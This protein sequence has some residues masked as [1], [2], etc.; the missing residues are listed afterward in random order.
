MLFQTEDITS[1][2][3]TES[4]YRCHT[5]PFSE[6]MIDIALW[7][8]TNRYIRSVTPIKLPDIGSDHYPIIFKIDANLSKPKF[9]RKITQYHRVDWT[10]ANN[11]I[12]NINLDDLSRNG[13][14]NIIEKVEDEIRNIHNE[15]PTKT[16]TT[17]NQGLSKEI[18]QKIKEKRR[19]IKISKRTRKPE[20]KRAVNRISKEIK[21]D[22][23]DSEQRKTKKQIDS[24]QSG[25]SRRAWKDFNN[26]FRKKPIEQISEIKDPTTNQV[27]TSDGD[28]AEIFR[29][30]QEEIFKGNPVHD[31]EHEDRV[32]RWFDS[33]I[34][35][36]KPIQIFIEKAEIRKKIK[37]LKNNKAPGDDGVTNLLIKYLE[38]SL[39]DILFQIY[40]SCY[41]YGMFPDR[42]KLAKIKMLHK[43]ESKLDPSNYRPISLLNQFGKIFESLIADI[44]R[45]WAEDNNKL[46]PIQAGFR[47]KRSTNDKL[48]T[49]SQHCFESFNR[50]KQADTI[51]I[52]FEKAFDKVWHRGLLYKLKAL[53]M[54][55]EDLFMVK[56]FL[57]N[58]RCFV[59]VGKEKSAE[60]SP[61]NGVPQGSCLSPLLFILYVVG[62]PTNPKIKQSKFADDLAL[63][64][65][66]SKKRRTRQI[67]CLYL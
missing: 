20:D 65:S 25:D 32:N 57:E 27:K 8:T 4:T 16:I 5:P 46:D 56:S 17:S 63:S 10:E 15:I 43:K 35:Y 40:N 53:R 13:I 58:R 45:F 26:M 28:I 38:P 34:N 30:N 11:R 18:R 60:F 29:K 66:I 59:Q 23:R 24:I 7:K 33:F 55:D 51:F 42:W 44:I 3:H 36:H 49:L 21:K 9:T 6:S 62:I 39:T 54:P 37:K 19:L 2:Y 31:Q 50:K 61:Q 1:S 47:R 22:I 52:D 48:Y 41:N 14:N 12:R 64:T 67:A